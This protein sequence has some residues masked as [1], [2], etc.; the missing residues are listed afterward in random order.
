MPSTLARCSVCNQK[1]YR[2]RYGRMMLHTRTVVGEAIGSKPKAIVC[3]G[4]DKGARP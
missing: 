1:A 4:S 2:N 3:E